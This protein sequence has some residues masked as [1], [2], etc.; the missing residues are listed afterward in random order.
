MRG[1]LLV[2]MA[3][4]FFA[5]S[6]PKVNEA[7]RVN[8]FPRTIERQAFSFLWRLIIR[9][10][11]AASGNDGCANIF[12]VF[13]KKNKAEKSGF[14]DCIPFTW[15]WHLVFTVSRIFGHFSL[16]LLSD[17]LPLLPLLF[18][19]YTIA[20]RISLFCHDFSDCP[21]FLQISIR[22]RPLAGGLGT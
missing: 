4:R 6:A 15:D 19:F 11:W 18:P 22:L 1:W 12:F 10:L 9:A 17:A 20:I 21:T 14:Y 2:K 5:A 13:L 3:A 7:Q 8:C 16:F